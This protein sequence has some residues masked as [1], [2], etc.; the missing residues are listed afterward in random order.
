MR[1]PRVASWPHWYEPNRYLPLF[2]ESLSRWGI[3]HVRDVPPRLRSFGREGAADV[4]HLHWPEAWWRE[5]GR[6]LPRRLLA[7]AGLRR[8]LAGLRRREV[9]VVWT[10]HNLLPHGADRVADRLGYRLVHRSADLRVFHSRWARERDREARGASGGATIVMPHGAYHGVLPAPAPPERTRAAMSVPPGRRVL[11]CFGQVRGY[12]GFD[13]AV[14]ALDHLPGGTFHLIVAGRPVGPGAV[15]VEEHARGRSDVRLLLEEVS[16][17]TLADLLGVAEAVLLPYREVTSSGTLLAALTA[18]RGVVA[19]DLP[20]L[21]EAVAP[22]PGAAEWAAPG[23]PASLARA[24]E[25]FVASDGAERTAAALALAER[26]R[27]EEVVEPVATWLLDR[28]GA[29]RDPA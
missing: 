17:R 12:K 3:R 21:R 25:R 19:S 13:V 18:G 16:D 10:V 23:D 9:P 20:P 26:Y 4:L 11:L 5:A 1:A 8:L 28:F 29:P 27:W 15:A 14:R 6:T 2:Y 22:E 7:V 24:V